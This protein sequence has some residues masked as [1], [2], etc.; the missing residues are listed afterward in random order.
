MLFVVRPVADVPEV[1]PDVFRLRIARDMAEIDGQQVPLQYLHIYTEGIGA[2]RFELFD[3][4]GK[5]YLRK[6]VLG[7][8]DE[9]QSC[10]ERTEV[11]AEVSFQSIID[12]GQLSSFFM[13]SRGVYQIEY[14]QSQHGAL[15]NGFDQQLD[16][17]L[18]AAVSQGIDSLSALLAHELIDGE[19]SSASRAPLAIAKLTLTRKQADVWEAALAAGY[20]YDYLASELP[21]GERAQSFYLSYL[22]RLSGA[23]SQDGDDIT[24]ATELGALL[25]FRGGVTL[26]GNEAG[27][28]IGTTIASRVEYVRD[29]QADE[30]EGACGMLKRQKNIATDCEAVA[31]I[32]YRN[33][34][35]GVSREEQDGVYVGRFA[36]GDLVV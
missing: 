32:S 30:A 6:C 1:K 19:G 3:L 7:A 15:D 20:D 9:V 31:Y 5:R 2:N 10:P 11:D 28:S 24:V 8:N 22:T 27:E 16:G 36:D 29:E 13:P 25:V 12:D 17:R 21:T 26:L 23:T 35:M 34:L 4:D 14:D 33:V 18:L